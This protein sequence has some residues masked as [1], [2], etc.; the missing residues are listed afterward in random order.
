[1]RLG[2]PAI[3]W[4]GVVGTAGGVTSVKDLFYRSAGSTEQALRDIA[5]AGYGGTELFDGNLVEFELDPQRLLDLLTE[6]GLE[7][8]GVYTGANFIFDGIVEEE[9][10][11]IRRSVDLAATFGASRLVVGGGAQRVGG[12]ADGDFER[13]AAGLDRCSD[14]ARA[15]GLTAVY[16]PHLGTLVETPAAL[17]RLMGLS[18][19]DFCP[20]TAHL[21]GG[22]GDPADLIRTFGNRLAHVHLKD[23]DSRTR[24][25]LPLGQGE[26]D[27][28]AIIEA[29]RHAGYDD[30]LMVELDCYDGDPREAA[31]ISRH[32]LEHLLDIGHLPPHAGD[33]ARD[34]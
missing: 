31:Q 22:G 23:W 26:L 6:T 5:G 25:F 13:L 11:K 15:A 18:G 27:F 1:M 3:T 16:H 20:D 4:G 8:V 30:W 32:Y 19:I 21:A 33:G 14:I 10:A 12:P 9:F 17:H 2:C 34:Q 7:L 24:R 29:I 28:P